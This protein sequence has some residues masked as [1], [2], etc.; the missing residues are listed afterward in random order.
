[1]SNR[2]LPLNQDAVDPSSRVSIAKGAIWL[3][4]ELA[5]ELSTALD[6]ESLQNILSRKL[7][8]ILDFDRSTLAVWCEPSEYEY[9][10]LEITSSSK[11]K[12]TPIQKVPLNQGWPGRVIADSKPYFLADLSQLPPS[13]ELPTEEHW[14][15]TPQ[16]RSLMILPLRIGDYI[17]GSLNFSSNTP[18]TYSVAWRN[19]AELLAGQVG[20]QL[21]SIL[22]YQQATAALRALELSQA[23]LKRAV[24]FRERVME[25]ATNAIYT[26][27][28]SGSFI[29]VNYRTAEMTGYGAEE[30][31]GLSFCE[32]FA[33][34]DAFEIQKQITAISHG[35]S[36]DQYDVEL[37]RKDGTKRII[38]FGLAPLVLEGRI[39]AVVGTAQDITKRKQ[40][41]EVLLRAKVA[42]AAQQELEKEIFERKRM[43]EK[44]LYDA[45]HDTLTGLPNRAL[46]MD[47]L[48]H[49]VERSKRNK[50]Y[51]FAVLFLDL[52][53]FK[54]I[55]DS[56]G[57]TL[58]D[59]LLIAIAEK[60][61]A[62][63]RPTDTVVRLGGDEFT[64]LLE[65]IKDVSDAIRV[66]ERIQQELILPF[67]LYE[68][69]IFTSASIGI[70]LNTTSDHRPD[71]LLRDADIAMYRAKDLGK[72]R[73][74][75]FNPDMHA[76]AVGR[77]QMETAL[78][79]AIERHEFRIYYQPIISLV[80]GRIHGF[81]ALVRW[82]HPQRGLLSPAE[83]F[84]VAEETTLSIPIDRWVLYEACRQTQQWQEL[85]PNNSS[86][87]ISVNL[88][89]PQFKQ[90]DLLQYVNQVLEK[91]HLEVHNLKLEITENIIMDNHESAT[92]KLS[93][94]RDLGIQLCIDDFGTG[95]SSLGRLHCFPIDV[96]KIDRSFVGRTGNG[97]ESNSQA[98]APVVRTIV[99]LAY[100]LGV[101]VV[102]EGIETAVQ[103][104]QLREMNCGYG[105]GYFFSRP[106][107]SKA[108]EAMIVENPQW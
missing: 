103:L 63:V 38:T 95:Y 97:K 16:A 86:L 17:I 79:R 67:D 8:W 55:N 72:A 69:E 19:L 22:A 51:L 57:H 41:E 58:G 35:V 25:S 39:S 50:D 23:Q 90:P 12:C 101:D 28:L 80:N 27:D 11:A 77:L 42:E 107:D 71:D 70:A 64:I 61:K 84:S 68:Q 26:L 87:T 62:C 32:L 44:L 92:V 91:T 5:S 108:A 104:T 14:G 74:E 66:A 6:L 89:G 2:K 10:L 18:C 53:R 48:K 13:V 1:M 46:F 102:A 49:A 106:L 75:I 56:L 20:G 82:Q 96:L 54:V 105:Q 81:E 45:F 9:L 59:Q 4:G 29:A 24:E 52:D 76:W 7:R 60:L 94:L 30:L 47:R 40:M 88:S 65:D 37:I 100:H 34:D 21:G 36:I 98:G 73:Y 33:A 31:V 83:F 93:Q 3:L 43:E 15:I 99:T 85:L 78:R